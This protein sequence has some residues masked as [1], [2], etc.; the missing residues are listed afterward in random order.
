MLLAQALSLTFITAYYKILLMPGEQLSFNDDDLVKN[1][2]TREEVE[3]VMASETAVDCDM[4]PSERGNDRVII[5]G[6]TLGVRLVEVGIE[7]FADRLHVFH[8]SDATKGYRQ[9]FEKRVRP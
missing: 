6:F 3:Q 5:V 8:A 4:Q 9:E 2:V 7:F 1:G